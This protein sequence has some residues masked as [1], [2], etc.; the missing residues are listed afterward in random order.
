MAAAGAA[1]VAVAADYIMATTEQLVDLN[2]KCVELAL[3]MSER[4]AGGKQTSG[5]YKA[6]DTARKKYIARVIMPDLQAGKL[7]S[8]YDRRMLFDVP[9]QEELVAA[10]GPLLKEVAAWAKKVGPD[11]KSADARSPGDELV[12]TTLLRWAAADP[13]GRSAPVR[14]EPARRGAPPVYTFLFGSKVGKTLTDVRRKDGNYMRWLLTEGGARCDRSNPRSIEPAIGQTCV[15]SP[16]REH[17]AHRDGSSA[18]R[19]CRPECVQVGFRWQSGARAS[20]L[21]LASLRA[22]VGDV[23]DLEWCAAC[24]RA[25][26]GDEGAVC[27]VVP[28]GHWLGAAAR[29]R[30]GAE[31]RSIGCHR[32]RRRGALH[33][34]DIQ[35]RA[36]GDATAGREHGHGAED[37]RWQAVSRVDVDVVA[38]RRRSPL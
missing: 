34:R 33:A 5:R 21:Q 35:R 29:G 28:R 25:E 10:G 20:L 30:A 26:Q 14:S 13:A 31:A 32:R 18:S 1:P 9:S 12:Q 8:A 22:R 36:G 23:Y 6:H 2:L 38:S 24:G 16:A 37:G 15:A 11:A 17:M 3:I 7:P 19:L 27:R 4:Q